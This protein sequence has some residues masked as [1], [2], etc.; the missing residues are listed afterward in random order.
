M[1]KKKRKKKISLFMRIYRVLV[2]LSVLVIVSS[3]AWHFVVPAPPVAE[4]IPANLVVD[5]GEEEISH[6]VSHT[7][8]KKGYYT[9]LLVGSDD[10]HG[11]ADTIMVVG[12]DTKAG[13]VNLVSV[14]RDTLV[15]RTWSKF[16]KINAAFSKGVEVLQQEVSYTLGIPLDFTVVIGL[17]A[18][19]DVVD[20]LG[21]I[22]Y[23][24]PQDMYHDDQGGFVIDL[25]EGTQ[26]LDGRHTLELVRY[27]GYANADIGR[28]Q[29]Q[30]EVMRLLVGKLVSWNSLGKVEE[31]LAI[32]QERVDTTLATSDLLW[33][34][35]A[36]LTNPNLQIATHTLEGRGD[37]NY[38]GYAWCYQLDPQK[39]LDTVNTMISPY[40]QPRTLEDLT[41]HTPG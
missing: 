14:P 28:T 5:P 11:N 38:N 23:T 10:G 6:P 40:E 34:A 37:V 2:L 16:P 20:A 24:V 41:I 31:F 1:A 12:F 29:T 9:F 36:V 25:K 7:Q 13:T 27:R 15:Y 19:V 4:Y 39:T 17:E 3:V 26:H 22:D 33:F 18:F 8:R 35:K 21:G 32:Y 30:Q